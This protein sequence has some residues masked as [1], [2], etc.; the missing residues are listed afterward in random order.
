MWDDLSLNRSGFIE[1]TRDS[2]GQFTLVALMQE[3]PVQEE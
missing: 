1:S 3:A 2:V